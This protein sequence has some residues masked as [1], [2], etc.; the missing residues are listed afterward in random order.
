LS[1]Q[2]A[3]RRPSRTGVVVRLLNVVVALAV[4]AQGVV[5]LNWLVDDPWRRSTG[6]LVFAL[7]LFGVAALVAAPSRL[8]RNRVVLLAAG[9]GV[10]FLGCEAFFAFLLAGVGTSG[11]ALFG[12]IAWWIATPIIATALS[13]AAVLIC[14]MHGG[15]RCLREVLR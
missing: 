4:A 2:L 12:G 6:A 13:A 14:K 3:K 11:N 9:L 8:Y 1:K 10:A 7:V 5:I 15:L